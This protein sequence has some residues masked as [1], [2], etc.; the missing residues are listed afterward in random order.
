[1]N[2][3]SVEKQEKSTVE[4][5]IQVGAE[6]F[7]AAVEKIYK[8]KRASI[9]VPGFRKGHAPRKVIEGMYGSGVF[10]EDAVN[11]L[12]PTAYE[13]AVKQEKLDAVAWPKVEIQEMGKDGFT[14]KAVVTVRP[15]VKLGDYKGLSAPKDEVV[16]SD[17][18]L[19]GELKP[20]I[21]RASR[22]V[23][24]EREA[25][26]GDVAVIDFEGFKDGVPFEGGK[27]EGYSLEL[28][29]GTF[30][31]GFE[32][33]VV[34]LKAGEEKDL[35]VT[36]PEDYSAEDLAGAAVVFHVKV[37]DVK[38]KE[39]PEL[40][41]EFAK[42]VSEFDT[43]EAFKAD[44]GA[45]LK[46]RQEAQNL[47]AFRECLM[48]QV[49]DNMEVEI[50]EAMVE[51]Q[52]ERIFTNYAQR[53]TS[54]GI[55]FEDYLRLTGQTMTDMRSQA[56][57][58]ANHQVRRDLALSAI[59]AAENIQISE[60][61]L[62]AEYS[63]MAEQFKLEVAKVKESVPMEDLKAELAGKKAADLVFDSAKIGPAPEK[64]QE[65]KAAKAE[66]TPAEEKPAKP[67]RTRKKKVEETPTEK[68]AED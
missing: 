25:Q 27:G 1:M 8:K 34:G 19:A 63:R 58:A 11:E 41:D 51:F 13:E 7:E 47:N 6:E 68:K 3:K 52:A 54:Q 66:D 26:N 44:L 30:I 38:V 18:D 36:F 61:E 10:Y 42:D 29:S 20:Y 49:V 53:V 62:D 16:I 46:E 43:L 56:M 17:E 40:D 14:F 57:D 23:T 39:R 64:K 32:E 48:D 65:E 21:E 31:P 50:P 28:G 12:Y 15:E 4:L 9:N 33:Q 55:P 45:K 24:V 5:I 67:K 35:N 59:A 22:L 37:N 2:V 60:E